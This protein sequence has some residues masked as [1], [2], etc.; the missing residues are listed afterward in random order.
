MIIYLFNNIHEKN[1]VKDVLNLTDSELSS[2]F[3]VRAKPQVIL[4]VTL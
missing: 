2:Q 3:C 4:I 1:F